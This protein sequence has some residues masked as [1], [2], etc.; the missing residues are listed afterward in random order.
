MS[1]G[2]RSRPRTAERAIVAYR[3]AIELDPVSAAWWSL[4]TNLKPCVRAGDIAAMQRQLQRG[5][6][7]DDKRHFEFALGK[8]MEDEGQSTPPHFAH[9]ASGNALQ[10]L[11]QHAE[12]NA[13]RRRR[14]QA[15]A[16]AA[17][18]TRGRASAGDPAPVF[19]VGMPRGFHP[20]RARSCPAIPGGAT[21]ELPDIIAITRDCARAR[22][23]RKPPPTT[24]SWRAGPAE[25]E[26]L[27]KRYLETTRV[28]R[29]L[30]QPFFIDKMPNNFARRADQQTDPAE[31]EDHRCA[32]ASAGL[33]FSSFKQH[34]ARGQN[35]SGH[36][37][38]AWA[39]TT[40]TTWR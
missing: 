30:G 5:S 15:V 8:A 12:Q 17:S 13:Q 31:R 33:R 21:M 16:R 11:P 26:S 19:I 27:G 14:A 29:K 37:T 7:D 35:F 1:T 2:H 3:R 10:L 39:A 36:L 28:Q 25:F 4:A 23:N 32:P 6:L 20:G 18:S 38:D 40:R 34:F 24:T 22:R 9:Y